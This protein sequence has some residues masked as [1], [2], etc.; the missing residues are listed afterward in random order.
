MPGWR[1]AGKMRGGARTDTADV[2]ERGA[3][4]QAGE[5]RCGRSATAWV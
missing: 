1:E 4:R 3:D 5:G 2:E